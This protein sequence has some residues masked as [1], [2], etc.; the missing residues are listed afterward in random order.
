MNLSE[1]VSNGVSRARS[2]NLFRFRCAAAVALITGL[3][4][5]AG[6]YNLLRTF[7]SLNPAIALACALVIAIFFLLG[8]VNVWWLL[9]CR[10]A[11]RYAT[12]LRSYAYGFSLGLLSPGQIGD[13]SLVLFLRNGG[14]PVS[15]SGAAYTMDKLITLLVL[16]LIAVF[17]LLRYRLLSVGHLLIGVAILAGVAGVTWLLIARGRSGNRLVTAI[18]KIA[19]EIAEY[20]FHLK[21]I[22]GNV[23]LTGLKWLVLCVA[24]Y[25]AFLA[26][27]TSVRWPDIGVI[28]VMS[29]L[30]GYIPISVAGIGTVEVSA[31][32]LFKMLGVAEAIVISVYLFL[33]SLQYLLALGLMGCL[34][35]NVSKGDS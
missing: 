30:V 26:F 11:I 17:G 29:T 32:M 35:D 15:K 2:F 23:L 22:L 20:R 12:F 21:T 9:Q 31:V 7:A 16:S 1:Q 27:G 13:V 3:V 25:L 33:R 10:H 14:V 4:W 28:P 18:Q 34:R 8:S 5:F 24:Y 6:P 19:R